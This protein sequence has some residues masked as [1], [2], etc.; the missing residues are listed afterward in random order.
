M[1]KPFSKSILIIDDEPDIRQLIKD[2]LTMNFGDEK[3]MFCEAQN[4]SEGNIKFS[5]QKFDLIIMD[6]RMPKRDGIT[7]LK[8]IFNLE[9][10]FK[11]KDIIIISGY[12]PE[13][14]NFPH[15]V[16]FLPKPFG[17]EGLVALV[18]DCF[19][20]QKIKQTSLSYKRI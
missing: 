14:T 19:E 7:T 18:H 9:D 15:G 5:Q 13:G 17:K 3:F 20:K 11:P 4:G 2:V 1:N 10:E 12:V 16:N 6:L 8:D